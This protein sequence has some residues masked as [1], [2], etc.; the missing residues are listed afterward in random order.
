[1]KPVLATLFKIVIESLFE[2]IF[3]YLGARRRDQALEQAGVEKAEKAN[4]IKAAERANRVLKA[5]AQRHS[6]GD[7][8]DSMRDGSF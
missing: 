3:D 6:N 5:A 1:M 2:G 4:A 7:I 8:A